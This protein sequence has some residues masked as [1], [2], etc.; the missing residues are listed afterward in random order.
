MANLTEKIQKCAVFLNTVFKCL[1]SVG[2][3]ARRTHKI[4]TLLGIKI[5]VK[6]NTKNDKNNIIYLVSN[7]GRMRVKEIKGLDI[8]F[9]G[10]NASVEI[11]S[12][13]QLRFNNCKMEVGNNAFISIGSSPHRMINSA[14]FCIAENSRII[15]GNNF[16]CAG[17]YIANRD[18]PGITIEIG[19]DCMCSSEVY[20]RSS[21]GHTILDGS[22]NVIN[23][24]VRG[25]KIGNHVWLC[26]ASRILKD[27]SVGNNCIVANRAVVTKNFAS[28]G[29][30]LVIAGV[31]AKI[32]KSGINWDR[33]QTHSY[34][35]A[36][37]KT[38]K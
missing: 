22:G 16:S 24:P 13:P 9:K 18:E 26:N 3:D 8:K 29:D 12:C 14:I 21:D 15:I 6:R 1:F 4:I 32:V 31:P 10:K 7:N 20:I 35:R 36:R 19:N 2:N 30:N 27:S 34:E 5:K 38:H 17:V 37:Q 11:G 33:R 28:M 23:K 25:V